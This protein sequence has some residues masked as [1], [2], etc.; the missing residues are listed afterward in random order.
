[1][2]GGENKRHPRKITAR[3]LWFVFE[4][5]GLA[6]IG[7][8]IKP[9]DFR[10]FFTQNMVDGVPMPIAFKMMGHASEKTTQAHHYKLSVDWRRVIWSAFRL[11]SASDALIEARELDMCPS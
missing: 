3:G 9:K 6:S 8:K 1:M 11:V 5:A 7:R 2:G 10:S 4:A